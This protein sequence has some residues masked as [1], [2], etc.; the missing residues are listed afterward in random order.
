[1][2]AAGSQDAPSP[3]RVIGRL[4]V[5]GLAETARSRPLLSASLLVAFVALLIRLGY[6]LIVR[7]GGLTQADSGGYILLAN[8]L[9]TTGSYHVNHVA[10]FP[11]DLLRPPGYSTFLLLANGG[12][13]ISL[14]RVALIQ[15]LLGASFAGALTYVVSRW[16]GLATGVLAGAMLAIDW[17]T[18]L[19][20]PLVLSDFL[21]SVLYTVALAVFA[22]YLMKRTAW[23]P[24]LSGVC[25]A[26]AT[27][28]KPAGEFGLAAV[29][30]ATL[31]APRL[32]WK[33]TVAFL[34]F[35]ALS[36]PWA[37]RNESRYH[38]FSLSTIPSVNTY[39]YT[40]EVALH[41]RLFW[42]PGE[43]TI[44]AD[45]ASS[46]L[47]GLH[48]APSALKARMDNSSAT[49]ILHHLPKVIVQA[50][51]GAAR[52]SFGTGRD[53]LAQSTKDTR[54]PPIVGTGV[55]LGQTILMWLLAAVGA[56]AA[57]R[58]QRILRSVTV[59]LCA[60]VLVIILPAFSPVANSRFRVPA[61]PLLCV[62]AAVGATSSFRAM[63]SRLQA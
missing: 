46:D 19:Y 60:G 40:A 20:T 9:A 43:A 34:A 28:V 62:L 53:T 31:T 2:S 11:I 6:F 51:L 17:T 23:W 26:L 4:N 21:L 42:S 30:I 14:Q 39:S 56:A 32:N 57:W 37:L 1:M 15:V 47:S 29:L 10:L 5:G 55:P 58:S 48:L 36:L 22:L 59:L 61:T 7:N 27:L 24:L 13:R 63:R 8:Q 38:V 35:A 16:L 52:S 41:G 49:I 25:L 54:I 45:K 12:P 3:I 44:I 33:G 50:G 18:V